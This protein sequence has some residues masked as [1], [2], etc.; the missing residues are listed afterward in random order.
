MTA[1]TKNNI[2][3]NNINNKNQTM[4]FYKH[5]YTK[6]TLKEQYTN[7]DFL[8]EIA[9]INKNNKLFIDRFGPYKSEITR[10]KK[11][12]SD[13]KQNKNQTITYEKKD[14][15]IGR[16]YP[17]E[18]SVNYCLQ[19]MPKEFRNIC[20]DKTA[21]SIDLVNAH[22]TIMVQLCKKYKFNCRN[23]NDYINNRTEWLDDI[24]QNYNVDRKIAKS[25]MLIQ[26]F[27]GCF[28]TWI[29]ENNLNT[30]FKPMEC[31]TK[32]YDE[33]QYVLN[34]I[35]PDNFP[36]YQA[37]VNVAKQHKG[38]KEHGALRSALGLYIQDVESQIMMCVYDYFLEHSGKNKIASIVHDEII[39]YGN[40]DT[41]NIDQLIQ[42]VL[43]NTGFN[44]N[45]TCEQF[46]K[47]NVKSEWVEDLKELIEDL[48]EEK[49]EKCNVDADD[50]RPDE[51][52]ADNILEVFKGKMYRTEFGDYMYDV[53]NGLW[54]TDNKNHHLRIIQQFSKDIFVNI[55]EDDEKKTFM[56]LYKNAY[57]LAWAKAPY[58]QRLDFKNNLGYL[59]F[60]NGVLN[61]YTGDLEPMRPELFFTKKIN[62]TYDL[63]DK[64][65]YKNEIMTKLFNNPFTKG[66]NDF[67][68]R[69]YVIETLARAVAVGGIDKQFSFII[70]EPNCGKGILTKLLLNSLDEFADTFNMG[71]LIVNG[72]VSGDNEKLWGWL[73][74]LWSCRIIVGNEFEMGT[75]ESMNNFGKKQT[76]IRPINAG[77][78]KTIVSQ[79]DTIKCRTLYK[80]PIKIEVLAYVLGLANDVPPVKGG[81][82]AYKNRANYIEADRSST[83]KT[84]FDTALFF[85]KDNNM[86]NFINDYNVCD[87]FIELM[88][89]Y[90]KLSVDNG[91]KPKPD[92]VIQNIKDMVGA[93]DNGF[94]WVSDNYEI[95]EGN[96]NDFIIEKTDK[97]TYR[98]D[99]D[100]VGDWFVNSDT[101]YNWY[102]N[103]GNA[104]SSAKFGKMLTNKNIYAGTKK[105][106]GRSKS[107]RVGLRKPKQDFHFQETE[108]D[109]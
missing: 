78:M 90:Y 24:Q 68:K 65:H 70:G 57:I 7:I 52:H 97:G 19:Q 14:Y 95:Y 100:K 99:W 64:T 49:A 76:D 40:K 67:E 104:D 31:V 55:N 10:I 85:P 4:P 101:I 26:T 17:V 39:L 88:C 60:N 8:T 89:E 27:G 86:E 54:R 72:P 53:D 5:N 41:V 21:F 44:M 33:I 96:I 84:E 51:I 11:F 25:L 106:N 109:C 59:L 82:A 2:C 87:A 83:E 35:A 107:V 77:L 108:V 15:N 30:K 38:K 61:M 34:S 32:Y 12:V 29:K 6:I 56:S 3:D 73:A 47:D 46:D 23:I 71:N 43:K 74:N 69:D 36:N 80:D 92:F 45:M 103:D 91:K 105:I 94:E 50:R 93:S 18:K 98:F 79:G 37:A 16:F 28:K 63:N 66:D 20:M 75:S 48:K 62:R 81:D 42:H 102:K 22:P 13:V 1:D 9:G 58:K